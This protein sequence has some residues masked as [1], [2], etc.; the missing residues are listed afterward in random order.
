V[1]A[2]PFVLVAGLYE[3]MSAVA[4]VVLAPAGSAE[5]VGD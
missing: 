1:N 3:A 4:V 2:W 5:R